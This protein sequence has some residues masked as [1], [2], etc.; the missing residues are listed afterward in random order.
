M[1]PYFAQRSV[2]Q[3]VYRLWTFVYFMNEDVLCSAEAAWE[4]RYNIFDAQD[5]VTFGQRHLIT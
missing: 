3:G 5:Y 2:Q 4:T 1:M